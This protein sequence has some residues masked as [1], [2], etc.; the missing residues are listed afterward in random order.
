MEGGLTLRVH[1]IISEQDRKD[2]AG[3]SRASHIRCGGRKES[4]MRKPEFRALCKGVADGEE[5]FVEDLTLHAIGKVTSC[6]GNH[7]QVQFDEKSQSW[8]SETCRERMDIASKKS[9]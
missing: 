4:V 9:A 8:P 6:S 1:V 5:R 3:R 7:F 2:A